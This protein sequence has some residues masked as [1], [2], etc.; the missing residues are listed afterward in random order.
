MLTSTNG[1]TWAAHGNSP[2]LEVEPGKWDSQ[3]LE[4]GV[5]Y[6]RGKYWLWYSGLDSPLSDRTI[7]AIGLATSD[8][9]VRW[10][11][12]PHNP[13]LSPGAKG[14]WNDARVLAPD[15]IVEPDGTLL[16]SAYGQSKQDIKE[17]SSSSSIGFW[18]SR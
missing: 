16:M 3:I 7:I 15:V 1:V 11:R 12:Y 2:V 18:R 17:N 10:S 4:Q 8:D 6:A 13:V 9:G 14:S 5:L